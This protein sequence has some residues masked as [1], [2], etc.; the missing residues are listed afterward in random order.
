MPLTGFSISHSIGSSA[1]EMP[2][3]AARVPTSASTASPRKRTKPGAST[4]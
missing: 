2:S 1:S 3:T 4:G